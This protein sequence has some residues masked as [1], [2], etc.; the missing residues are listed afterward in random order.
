MITFDNA[1]EAIDLLKRGKSDVVG[2]SSE[3]LKSACFD[4][5][6]G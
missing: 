1:V 4:S 5:S 2:L 6:H 3:H